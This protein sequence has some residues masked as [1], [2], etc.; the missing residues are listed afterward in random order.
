MRIFSQIS[1]LFDFSHNRSNKLYALLIQNKAYESDLLKQN[2]DQIIGV[3]K[4]NPNWA[5]SQK[6][7]H[8]FFLAER[9][10]TYQPRATSGQRP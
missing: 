1:H 2:K 7:G 10:S 6:V 9:A 5:H 4:S 8:C 3:S